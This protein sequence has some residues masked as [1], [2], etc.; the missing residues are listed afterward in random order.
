MNNILFQMPRNIRQVI[1]CMALISA[2]VIPNTNALPRPTDKFGK[3]DIMFRWLL[4]E[5]CY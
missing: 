5:F 3:F 1:L 2:M 4:A